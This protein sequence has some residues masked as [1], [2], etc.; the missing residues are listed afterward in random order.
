MQRRLEPELLDS[1]PPGDPDAIHSR[2]DLRVINRAMG[3]AAWFERTLASNIRSD[4][5][6]IELGSGTGELSSRLRTVAPRVDGIDR[7]PAPP[8]WPATSLWHQADIQAFTSWND[9]S[10]I[11][12]NLILHHFDDASLH[13]L[14]NAISP[15]ARLLLFSE[16]TRKR[17]NQY[18]WRILAPLGG[19]NHVTRHDGYVSIAAGFRGDELPRALGLDPAAWR[20]KISHTWLG[21]Y[22]LIAERRP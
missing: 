7:V 5:R 1:L 12:G 14:G 22:R 18:M 4:D 15:H 11:I 6:V 16:P 17:F 2:R 10:V 9:Y 13:A 3:N 20:W 8:S 21:A 19:A